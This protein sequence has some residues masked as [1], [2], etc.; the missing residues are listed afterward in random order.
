MDPKLIGNKIAQLRIEQDMTQQQLA[1]I[2]MVSNKTISKWENGGGLPDIVNIPS[3][4]KVLDISI[5]ELLNAGF[6]AEDR[7]PRAKPVKTIK[8]IEK[9]TKSRISK[10]LP[11]AL[12]LFLIV[13]AL[14]ILVILSNN[15]T[16]DDND[17]LEN[18]VIQEAQ[19]IDDIKERQLAEEIKEL[20]TEL[21]TLKDIERELKVEIESL[22][23]NLLKKEEELFK[24]KNDDQFHISVAPDAALSDMMIVTSTDITNKQIRLLIEEKNK[25]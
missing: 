6:D 13:S 17:L 4:A 19:E 7:S 1:D 16:L 11:L 20:E 22:R 2:L 15:L 21:K 23:D 24:A 5:D 10:K 14:T 3:L 18:P 25:E 12:A 8:S 9:S